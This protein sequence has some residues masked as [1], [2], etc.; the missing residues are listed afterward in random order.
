MKKFI[1]TTLV[2]F[3]L[4]TVIFCTCKDDSDSGSKQPDYNMT[5]TYTF[6]N[7][8][9]SCTWIFSADGKYQCTGYGIIGTKTGNWSSKGNDVTISY[10]TSDGGSISGNEV[11]T[12]QES[13]NQLTLTL[14]NGQISNLLVIFSLADKSVTLTK[15]SSSGNT[16]GGNITVTFSDVTANGSASQTTTQL[17]LTFSQTITGLSA[18]DIT[19]SGV[20]GVTKETLSGS[21]STYTLGIS[22]FSVGGSLGVAAEKTGYTISG[23]PKTVSIYYYFN[24]TPPTSSTGIEMVTITGGTFI[25]G[26]PST[27]YDR[28][29]DETQHSVTLSSFYM[30]KYQVTQEQYQAVMGTNPSKFTSAVAGESSTPGKLPVEVVSWYDALVFCNKLSI[31]EGLNP[32]YIISGSTDPAVWGSVPTVWTSTWNAVVMDKSKN[33]YRLPTEA[34]WEYA[35]RAGTTTAFNNGNDDCTDTTS[36]GAVAWYF[37]NSGSK[38]H[39]VGLKT[40]NAWELYDMHG[41]IFEMCWD[42]YDYYSSSSTNN[43]KGP[44]TGSYRVSRGGNYYR[45]GNEQRSAARAK[46]SPHSRSDGSGFRLVRS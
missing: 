23:S 6:T 26:S 29:D 20:S 38:T 2:C 8:G 42:W 10:A 34:E 28:S 43:P 33:G 44:V 11:F 5:G 36:V 32:V 31:K 4:I 27:E 17:T 12:V 13:G 45:L 30:S 3:A 24:S 40:A 9:G 22:G 14:K 21:G 25:M 46:G 16:G 35:C 39:Q 41:N 15:T 19:L 37:Y 18:D 7:A 1:K